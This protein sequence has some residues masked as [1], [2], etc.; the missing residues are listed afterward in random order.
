[1]LLSVANI[2]TA[3][4]PRLL[5]PSD[6]SAQ[7]DDDGDAEDTLFQV[8]V[9]GGVLLSGCLFDAGHTLWSRNRRSGQPSAN[10]LVCT[11]LPSRLNS[12]QMSSVNRR[13]LCCLSNEQQ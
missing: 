3:M 2:V 7:P 9:F 13:C 4:V 8:S 1:M 11:P 10:S 12:L 6:D 5:Q